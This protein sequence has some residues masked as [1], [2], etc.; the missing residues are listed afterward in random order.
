MATKRRQKKPPWPKLFI[1]RRVSRGI[2][3]GLRAAF[4]FGRSL[5]ND[6]R[7]EWGKDRPGSKA[8]RP[9]ASKGKPMGGMEDKRHYRQPDLGRAPD[10]QQMN[11]LTP[12]ELAALGFTEAEIAAG[13]AAGEYGQQLT[14]EE[15]ADLGMTP[16]VLE[17]E[18]I[19]PSQFVP[20]DLPSDLPEMGDAPDLGGGMSEMDMSEG[21][22]GGEIGGGAAA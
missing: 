9:P 21:I 3:K 20:E 11:Q 22:G 19:D 16:E 14:P 4:T 2:A 1:A 8:N 12:E 18:G 17:A 7:N 5:K 15:L 6:V 13:I 10:G